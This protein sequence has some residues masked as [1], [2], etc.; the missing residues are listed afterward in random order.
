MDEEKVSAEIIKG[1]WKK[2][3]NTPTEDQLMKAEQLAFC[4]EIANSCLMAVLTILV[5]NGV[6]ASEKSFIKN[7]TFMTETIT[8][9]ILKSNNMYHPLQVIMDMTTSIEID[10]DNSPNCEIDYDT[11]DDMIASYNSAMEPSDDI[12]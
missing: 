3:I 2:T 9:S 5:E 12:S 1:P 11:I 7:I 8:A 6:D 10:P 4:D